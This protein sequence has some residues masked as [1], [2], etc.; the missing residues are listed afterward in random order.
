MRRTTTSAAAD[1]LIVVPARPRRWLWITI[2]VLAVTVAIGMLVNALTDVGLH[3]AP[4]I[5]I[6]VSWIL[7]YRAH[8]RPLR[9]DRH[10]IVRQDT[11]RA[12][13]WSEVESLIEPGRWDPSIHLRTT[14]GKDRPTGFP[15]EHLRRLAELSGKPVEHRPSSQAVA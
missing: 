9:A 2:C 13:P 6:P 10:G 15:A 4:Q 5:F 12:T 1:V 3:T 7:Y 8:F 14:S 11:F